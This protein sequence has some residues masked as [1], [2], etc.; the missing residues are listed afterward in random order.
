[1]IL[2]IFITDEPEQVRMKLLAHTA[3]TNLWKSTSGLWL[4]NKRAWNV[5][6]RSWK[7]NNVLNPK[8]AS[9]EGCWQGLKG[10][11]MLFYQKIINKEGKIVHDDKKNFKW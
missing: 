4:Q 3:M 2:N 7:K 1:M 6:R 9:S 10:F 11:L 5:N 8:Y